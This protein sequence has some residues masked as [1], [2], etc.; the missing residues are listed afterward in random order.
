MSVKTE[1]IIIFYSKSK[2]NQLG[3]QG[4]IQEF[5]KGVTFV[6]EGCGNP[7]SDHQNM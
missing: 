5:S 3:A 2:E 7:L 6:K 1:L 4:Q